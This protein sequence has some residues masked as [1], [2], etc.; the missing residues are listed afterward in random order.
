MNVFAKMFGSDKVIDAARDGIDAMFYTE[1]EKQ[2]QFGTL[3]KLYEPFKLAQ[4]LLALIFCPPYAL[5]WIITF[6]MSCF[7]L[8]IKSQ[9]DLLGGDMGTIVGVIAGFY[10]GGGAIEGI[11]RGARQ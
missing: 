8:D 3:L 10:F 11:V 7:G 2:R 6:G 4:R 9:L 5:A 1:E